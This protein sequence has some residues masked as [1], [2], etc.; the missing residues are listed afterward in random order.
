MAEYGAGESVEPDDVTHAA[1]PARSIEERSRSRSDMEL[2]SNR[3]L[4]TLAG[5]SG[6]RDELQPRME[7]L[8]WNGWLS[9]RSGMNRLTEY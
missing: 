7:R 2:R 1:N 5:R 3:S 6:G 9:N 8:A 4:N